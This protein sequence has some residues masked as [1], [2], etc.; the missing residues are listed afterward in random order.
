M[1]RECVL[2]SSELSPVDAV[3][4]HTHWLIGGKEIVIR[5]KKA[6]EQQENETR[7]VCVVSFRS[8]PRPY[9]S[10]SAARPPPV[11]SRGCRPGVRP[12]RRYHAARRGA[13]RMHQKWDIKSYTSAT[14]HAAA[15]IHR[16]QT[17]ESDAAR[18]RFLY[19]GSRRGAVGRSRYGMQASPIQPHSTRKGT[20]KTRGSHG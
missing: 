16:H 2:E 9:V 15:H 14:E 5:A 4:V 12:P 18:A 6:R 10:F 11:G 17:V 19:D 1:T 3:Q 8:S 13:L 20:R 7:V